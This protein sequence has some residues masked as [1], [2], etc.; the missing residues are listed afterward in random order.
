MVRGKSAR[1]KFLCQ[2]CPEGMHGEGVLVSEEFVDKV[3]EVKHMRE[4]LMIVKLVIRKHLMNVIS[5]M[6]HMLDEASLRR[7]KWWFLVEI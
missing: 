6:C 4:C 1:Y 2:G 3:V 7:K 5:V